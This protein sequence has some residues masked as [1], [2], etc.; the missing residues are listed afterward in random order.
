MVVS[1]ATAFSGYHAR[2][3]RVFRRAAIAEKFAFQRGADSAEDASTNATFRFVGGARVYVKF[4]FG[5]KLLISWL[6]FKSA[7]WHCADAA[8]VSVTDL[9]DRFH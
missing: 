5:V 1:S 9:K 7:N 6:Y 8:P 2:S 4:T 3:N